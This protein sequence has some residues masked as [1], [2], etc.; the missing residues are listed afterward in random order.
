MFLQKIFN[1]YQFFGDTLRVSSKSTLKTKRARFIFKQFSR[2]HQNCM[3]A[4][5]F[6][7][8]NFSSPTSGLTLA[9]GLAPQP[10]IVEFNDFPKIGNRQ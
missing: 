1:F 3:V 2:I 10:A 6:A 9:S 8:V 5:L 4:Q 7:L